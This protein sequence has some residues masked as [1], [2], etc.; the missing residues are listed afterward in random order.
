VAYSGEQYYRWA[1]LGLFVPSFPLTCSAIRSDVLKKG[2]W[3]LP[4]QAGFQNTVDPFTC[5][6]FSLDFSEPSRDLFREK[7]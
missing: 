3:W 2:G 4:E 7:L 5:S 1:E 6:Y